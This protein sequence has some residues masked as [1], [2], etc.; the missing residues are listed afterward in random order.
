MI[1]IIENCQIAGMKKIS[2]GMCI[3]RQMAAK[4]HMPQQ[5]KIAMRLRDKKGSTGNLKIE[6]DKM[7]ICWYYPCP[8]C[9]LNFAALDKVY[10]PYRATKAAEYS[11]YYKKRFRGRWFETITSPPYSREV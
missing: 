3:K 11:A 10:A 9:F 5:V 4:E 2:L 6:F 7:L 8:N 1:D